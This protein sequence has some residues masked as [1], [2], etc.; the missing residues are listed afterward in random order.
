M[1]CDLFKL[2]NKYQIRHT[3]GTPLKGRSY[4]VLRLDSDDAEES[5]RGQCGH[6]CM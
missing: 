4:F 6:V 5:A 3:D 1:K 2:H